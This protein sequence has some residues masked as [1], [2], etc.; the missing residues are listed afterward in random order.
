[1]RAVL[2][3]LCALCAASSA[4]SVA[5]QATDRDLKAAFLIRFADFVTWPPDSVGRA[6]TVCLS[7]SHDFGNA[8]ESATKGSSI[9]GRGV[10]VRQLTR[11]D[12]VAG[13]QVLYVADADV[14]LLPLVRRQPVLTIGG[15]VGFCQRGGIINLRVVDRR[16]RFEINLAHA[17]ASGLA[18]DS[19]LL[20]LAVV[21]HGGGQ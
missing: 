18:V 15:D 9:R 21:V 4:A 7:P 10:L 2:V 12:S 6:F 13:C 20:R 17:K 5:G 14:H 1:M 19:Q 16:M 11:T 8:V 3:V